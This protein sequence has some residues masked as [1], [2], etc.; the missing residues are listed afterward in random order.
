MRIG[1]AEG[2]ASRGGSAFLPP[3][4]ERTDENEENNESNETQNI[5]NVYYAATDSGGSSV[6]EETLGTSLAREDLL[7]AATFSEWDISAEGGA[8]KIWRM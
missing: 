2:Q 8:G 4:V 6:I 5:K 7:K 3:P 1:Q